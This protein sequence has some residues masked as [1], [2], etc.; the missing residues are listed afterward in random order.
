MA[1]NDPES[2]QSQMKKNPR[3]NLSYEQLRELSAAGQLLVGYGSNLNQDDYRKHSAYKKDLKAV[4]KGLITDA[5]LVFDKF[6][7]KRAGGVL[8]LQ[9]NPGAVTPCVLFEVDETDLATLKRK[10]G[11][12]DFVPCIVQY[13][14]PVT[15]KTGELVAGTFITANPGRFQEPSQTYLDVVC[16]G[17]EAFGLDDRAVKQAAKRE[18]SGFNKQNH[19]IFAYGTLG[20]GE[21]RENVMKTD[22]LIQVALAEFLQGNLYECESGEYPCLIQAEEMNDFTRVQGD[23]WSSKA[24]YIP[25]LIS[26]LD[27]VEGCNQMRLDEL[28]SFVQREMANGKT[29]EEACA[30][31]Q[32]LLEN[33]IHQSLYRRLLVTVDFDGRPR[34]AWIYFYQRSMEHLKPVANNNWREHKGRWDSTFLKVLR[35]LCTNHGG[36][37]PFR[38]KLAEDW[39]TMAAGR[40]NSIEELL[41]LLKSG[42]LEERDLIKWCKPDGQKQRLPK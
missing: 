28:R 16:D 18:E 26:R 12:Y 20:R 17:Y 1:I 13:D 22:G 37:E 42:A 14:C 9:D 8:S 5:S 41:G 24:R 4:G 6:A 29:P 21:S 31:A 36:F 34:S 25:E 35:E 33:A 38:D 15:G 23:L 19:N 11:G 39:K 30:I 10:E 32:R 40:A 3:E 2:E 27:R 7:T